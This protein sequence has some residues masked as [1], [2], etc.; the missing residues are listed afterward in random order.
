MTGALNGPPN[1]TVGRGS[2]GYDGPRNAHGVPLEPL[3]RKVKGTAL[4]R[5]KDTYKSNDVI[6][7]ALTRHVMRKQGDDHSRARHVMHPSDMSHKDWCG[8]HDFYRILDTPLE[9][10]SQANPSFRMGN[11]LAEGHSIHEKY[12]TWLWEMGNLF[13][14]WG[15]DTCGNCWQALS[16]TLCPAC[17]KSKLRY[18]EV[19]LQ[20]YKL[21]VA[22][23][24][25]GA[26]HNLNG[27]T[28]L[29]EIKSIGVGTLRFEAPRLYNRYEDGETLENI[30]WKIQRPF[31]THIKQGQLYLWLAWPRY[32][33]IVFIYESKFHQATKEFVVGYQPNLIAP[34]LDV[35]RGVSSALES[36]VPPAR[37]DWVDGPSGKVCAS[38]PYRRTCWS[39]EDDAAAEEDSAPQPVRVKRSRPAVRKRQL[40]SAAGVRA[41]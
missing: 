41:T 16:P 33:S 26:V 40:G 12:Q 37:P 24:A 8:R 29:I 39:I 15:C 10:V 18:L 27:Y 22:G 21:H 34:L 1:S 20:N 6:L 28:G 5:L 36:G 23:H 9:K 3:R 35:V 31:T 38:C 13:G 32:D 7:P 25:D 2:P 11:V 30:W 14:D 17:G 4:H 19:P